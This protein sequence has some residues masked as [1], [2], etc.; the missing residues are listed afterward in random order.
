MD[1]LTYWANW[2]DLKAANLQQTQQKC[3]L[4]ASSED[5]LQFFEAKSLRLP[6]FVVV[7]VVMILFYFLN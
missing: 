3:K 4:R 2:Q 7:V 5:E 1:G 6:I